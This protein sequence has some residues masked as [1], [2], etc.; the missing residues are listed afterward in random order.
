MKW[1]V[2]FLRYIL[3]TSHPRNRLCLWCGV[4]VAPAD[5]VRTTRGVYCN[6]AHVEFDNNERQ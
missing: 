3:V 4:A 2:V 1:I 5:G 6:N